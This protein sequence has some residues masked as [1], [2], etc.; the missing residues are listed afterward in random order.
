MNNEEV[1][2]SRQQTDSKEGSF[3]RMKQQTTPK[4]SKFIKKRPPI[5]RGIKQRRKRQFEW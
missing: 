1:E 4:Y 5:R 3:Q 2:K